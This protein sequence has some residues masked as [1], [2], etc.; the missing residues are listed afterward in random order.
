MPF[1]VSLRK[2]TGHQANDRVEGHK[3][4]ETGLTVK[5]FLAVPAMIEASRMRDDLD[6]V[7]SSPSLTICCGSPLVSTLYARLRHALNGEK[8]KER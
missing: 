6:S 3:A 7:S 5:C 8:C 4:T 1:D 2:D